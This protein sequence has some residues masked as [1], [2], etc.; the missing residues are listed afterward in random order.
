[1]K[2]RTMMGALLVLASPLSS[3]AEDIDLFLGSPP[4]D[5]QK[6]NVLFIIDNTANWNT[7][8]SNE[9][10]ALVDTFLN[11]DPDAFN[12]GLMMFGEA[13]NLGYVRAAIRPMSDTADIAGTPTTY[14]VLYAAMINAFDVNGDKANA[15]TLARTFSEAYAYLKGASSVDT[16][17]NN[18]Y[19]K[20]ISR[21][22]TNNL[23]GTLASQRVHALPGNALDSAADSTYTAPPSGG[24]CAKTYV[25]YI[26]NN[27]S[28]GNVTKDNTA[29]N[30]ASLAELNAAAAAA[31]V[32]GAGN[33]ITAGYTHTAH[34]DN[35]ADEWA[36][37]MHDQDGII[38]YA[39]D[40]NPTAHPDYDGSSGQNNGMG[41][42]E[43]LRSFSEGVGGGKYFRVTSTGSEIADE[44]AGILTEIQAVNSVFAS[45]ALPASTTGQS[46]FLNQVFI[47]LFRPDG[48]AYPRW[49]GNLKQYQ[50]G[51][52]GSTV[53]LFDAKDELAINPTTGFI[54]ECS[55]SFWT[56]TTQ[57]TYWDFYD[58]PEE[59]VW[60]GANDTA[61]AAS[62][63]SNSPDGPYVEKGAQA[64][65]LR[66]QTPTSRAMYTCGEPTT[67]CTARTS[68][69]DANT[70]ITQALL[71][72]NNATKRTELINWARGE[73]NHSPDEN[74][75]NDLLT[76]SRAS[77]HGDVIH[78]QPVAL[79]Y[80]T[81]AAPE[82]IA[83]YGGNDGVLRAVNGNQ[84]VTGTADNIAGFVPGAEIWSFMPPEFWGQLDRL[85]ENT[86][87]V[88]F[89]ATGPAAGTSGTA[90]PYGM[91]GPITAYE[92]DI[93]AST[94][95]KYIFV[96]MRRGGRALYAF[97]VTDPDDPDLLWK[98]GCDSSSCSANSGSNS[99]SDIGQTWSP[100]NVANATGH[101][102]PVLIM[103]GGYDA[104]EDFDGGAG[105]ANHSCS[106]ADPGDKGDKIYVI[107]AANGDLLKVFDTERA[108]PGGVTLVPI[109][110]PTDADPNPAL[111]FAYATD[112]GG[113]VY[114]ISGDDGSGGTAIIGSTAPSTWIITKIAS[115]GCDE[116]A[117]DSCTANR[118]FLFG[119][120]VVRSQD[121]ASVFRVLVGSGDREKPLL[122][123]SG[124]A[125]IQNYFFSFIDKPL[126]PDWLDDD[127]DG[128][129]GA[130]LICRGRLLE[131]T[132][133]TDDGVAV[134]PD[135][136]GYAVRLDATEQ[137]VTNALVIGDVAY[138]STHSPYDV[139][140]DPDADVCENKLGTAYTYN[141]GFENAGGEKVY[142][143][144]GGLVPSPVG[145]LVRICDNGICTNEPFLIGG[146]GEN[147][148]IGGGTPS[149]GSSFEQ[150][151][152]RVYW[153]VVQ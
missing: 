53:K 32:T 43:L 129:C 141:I 150:S 85:R 114:R 124:A 81:D 56:S 51:R 122:S 26:G 72:V 3:V 60:C 89:P 18:G 151:K 131:V 11:M 91:D 38:F 112:T 120:D 97:N 92:G 115:F 67:S 93:G 132:S 142:I 135:L 44:L 66:A 41:N 102:N 46:V 144:P 31:G 78:S 110:N 153:N 111:A 58:F 143:I 104:C 96:G 40:V 103:G 90:K 1:M 127:D 73:D 116:D 101:T 21:D 136:K 148:P 61:K 149:S 70:A 4:A 86:E 119:P 113:N 55:R 100:A 98:R 5:S 52:S 125:D 7:A 126:V 35:Y 39:V 84:D 121:D 133:I 106:T 152:G 71:G 108:V 24:S 42:S 10:Q 94:D 12:V 99:W 123:Y 29:R 8:F 36:R 37:F 2:F 30:T 128:T 50:L 145:G 130:D 139:S 140:S 64:F 88:K 137:V 118:K 33:L 105:N 109:T 117:D 80:G 87:I 83:F 82:V 49:P 47:G 19:G 22:Y 74:G 20:N 9:K 146:G 68:F 77:V 62:E 76:A 138:F 45:V 107:D 48:S 34:Q 65:M 27:V 59:S 13:P 15:R 147:S 28:G 79:N 6:P 134:D 63:V 69:N 14:N 23:V 75:V 25:I 16:S 54:S 17:V 95:Q 57:D